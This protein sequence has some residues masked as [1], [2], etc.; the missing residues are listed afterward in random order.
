[1]RTILIIWIAVMVNWQ[2]FIRKNLCQKANFSPHLWRQ[3]LE[4]ALVLFLL[5]IWISDYLCLDHIAEIRMNSPFKKTE[6]HIPIFRGSCSNLE[7]IRSLLTIWISD[8]LCL[9]HIPTWKQDEFTVS[10]ISRRKLK[11]LFFFWRSCSN[12]E[13]MRILVF[14]LQSWCTG[15]IL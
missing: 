12:L 8:C 6:V 10:F 3:L 15:S 4:L 2:H 9:A 7:L 1:M 5:T 11:L 13:I 14:G